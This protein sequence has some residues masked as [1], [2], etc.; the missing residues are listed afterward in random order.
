MKKDKSKIKEENEFRT[1]VPI[2]KKSIK[3]FWR[4]LTLFTRDTLMGEPDVIIKMYI[5]CKFSIWVLEASQNI[6]Q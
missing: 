3:G 4:D 5:S 2:N 6:S 1:K